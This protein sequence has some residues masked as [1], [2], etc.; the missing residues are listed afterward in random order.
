M[1]RRRD[2]VVDDEVLFHFTTS[3]WSW[4]MTATP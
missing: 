3:G 1:V 4:S 2:I